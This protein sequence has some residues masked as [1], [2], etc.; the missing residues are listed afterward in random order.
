MKWVKVENKLPETGK[1]VSVKRDF[2]VG[3][4]GYTGREG[5]EWVTIGRVNK[6]RTWSLKS[7]VGLTL[8]NSKPTHWAYHE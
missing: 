1:Y 5:L 6:Y 7:T 4:G 3:T 2:S 8:N